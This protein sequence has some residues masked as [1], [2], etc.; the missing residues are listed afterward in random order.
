MSRPLEGIKVV[1][2]STFIVASATARLLADLG[3]EVVKIEAPNGDEWRRTAKYRQGNKYFD[4]DHN[5]VFDIYNTGKKMVSVNMK[6]GQGMEVVYKL[7]EDAD[8]FIT[9]TRE[10]LLEKFGL[11]YAVLKEKYPKLICT[12]ADGYGNKGPDKDL[13]AFDTTAFWARTGFLMDQAMPTEDGSYIP[14]HAPSSV[15]DTGM[16]FL[17]LAEI[18]IALRERDKD[19]KGREVRASLFQ[20]G[21]FMMGSMTTWYQRQTGITLNHVPNSQRVATAGLFPCKDGWLFYATHGKKAGIL[22]TLDLIG[23]PEWIDLPVMKGGPSKEKYEMLANEFRKKTY[24]EWM[25]ICDKTEG[26]A[27]AKMNHWEDASED[28][29]AWAN[30]F[31]EKVEYPCGAVDTVPA[32]PIRIEGVTV[33]KTKPV[34]YIGGDS[35]EI[36]RKLGYSEEQIREMADAGAIVVDKKFK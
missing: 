32:S 3:A 15:G 5:P 1:E 16:A 20:V 14:M 19:G 2:I 28:E 35:A 31:F 18:M 13:P 26:I 23:H 36:L 22:G 24:A 9:N 21:L 11:N 8:I 7:L 17:M 12:Y 30:G 33:P 27:P 25:E 10:V 29:Q 34:P 6:T 4:F